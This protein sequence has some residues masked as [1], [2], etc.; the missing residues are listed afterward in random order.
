M[1]KPYQEGK[2][3][4]IRLRIK[5]QDI[6]RPGFKSAADARKEAERLRYHVSGSATPQHRG[7][8][9]TTVGEA[10]QAYAHERLPFMK[11]A[12]Q[13]GTRIN[14]YLRAS[15]LDTVRLSAAHSEQ[16]SADEVLRWEVT[17]APASPLRQIP[18][19]LH[20]HR[21]EQAKRTRETD[22][23]RERISRTPM[24]QVTTYQIQSLMSAMGHDGYKPATIGLERAMLRRLFNYAAK[25]WHWPDPVKNPAKDLVMPK[26]EN[27]RDRVLT[28]TEWKKITKSLQKCR[29]PF[30]APALALLLESAM[31]VSEPLLQATW[32]D[33][34][35]DNCLLKLRDAKAGSRLVPLTPSAV[36]TLRILQQLHA[37][38]AGADPRI[39]PI[40]YEALRAA[41]TRACT[42]AGIENAHIHDLRHTAATRFT[43][44]LCG[45][46][47]V[48]KIITG[49][50]TVSQL[51][52]YINVKASD[53]ARLLH[54]RSLT[55]GDAPA[56][57]RADAARITTPVPV[58]AYVDDSDL[59]DNVIPLRRAG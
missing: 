39:I 47:P 14:R 12:P 51:N 23:Q 24:A 25:V 48:L 35:F 6:Y 58:L 10:L 15:G 54:G 7:P 33:V 40:T 29:N 21:E 42:S 37:K 34:D 55:E 17:L 41:W 32:S 9:R 16:P 46:I 26:I 45:N 11:G 52:R 44:E 30:V 43:L 50:K 49:H 1:V 13:E 3:W 28:N 59:P 20:A 27:E 2:T 22:K 57:L 8:W 56:G 18:N 38:L 5:G 53:V 19:G 31:R 36:N 4:S